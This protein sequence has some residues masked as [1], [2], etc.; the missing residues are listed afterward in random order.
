MHFVC[1]KFV[2][3]YNQMIS[4]SAESRKLPHKVG[5]LK[6]PDINIEDLIVSS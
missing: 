2:S 6:L 5:I 4:I 1:L 3:D